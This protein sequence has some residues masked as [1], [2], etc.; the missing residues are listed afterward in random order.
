MSVSF[1][2]ALETDKRWSS[3]VVSDCTISTYRCSTL[4]WST[5]AGG[6][7]GSVAAAGQL[8]H[9]RCFVDAIV[10]AMPFHARRNCKGIRGRVRRVRVLPG[11]YSSSVTETVV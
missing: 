8:A 1:T 6:R 11:T 3:I 7:G 5:S 4:P 2:V 9:Q 10:D